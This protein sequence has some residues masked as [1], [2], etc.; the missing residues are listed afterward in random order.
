M[1]NPFKTNR[2]L[3]PRLQR[4]FCE[5]EYRSAAT[6]IKTD[7]P[8]ASAAQI[9]EAFLAAY[10]SV[11]SMCARRVLLATVREVLRDSGARANVSE[12]DADAA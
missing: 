10:V 11:P 3:D 2:F 12:A 1:K 5:Q 4:F 9:T 7:F 8:G 6:Q